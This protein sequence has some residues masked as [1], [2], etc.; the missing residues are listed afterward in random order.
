MEEMDV[1]ALLAQLQ[2][3]KIVPMT[4]EIAWKACL[5][6][7]K[8]RLATADSIIYATALSEKAK[9]ITFDNLS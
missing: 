3:G 2:R 5:Q 7:K 6:G 9:L 1:L 4:I 8:W